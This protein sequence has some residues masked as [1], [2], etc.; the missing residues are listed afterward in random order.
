MNAPGNLPN[1]C[2]VLARQARADTY[3]GIDDVGTTRWTPLADGSITI[4]LFRSP[5][6][7][8]DAKLSLTTDGFR[9]RGTSRGWGVAADSPADSIVGRRIGPP[10]LMRCLR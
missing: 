6:A 4:S 10:E 3:A 8:Y 2:Y 5:D 9:G 1:A 7:G